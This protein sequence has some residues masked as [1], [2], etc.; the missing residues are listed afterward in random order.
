MVVSG[1]TTGHGV[2]MLSFEHDD[3]IF[4]Q[5]D[6]RKTLVE[7]LKFAILAK[8]EA[9]IKKD[10]VATWAV[11]GGGTP[12]PLF[13]AMA[14]TKFSWCNVHVALVDDRWVSPEHPRSNEGF[15]KNTLLKG[16]AACACF[17]GM[18][19]D[20]SEPRLALDEVEAAY[21]V[22]PQ[23]F[24]NV[25][26][27]MGNDGHTAS[28]FPAAEGL[29]AAMAL[30]HFALCAAVTAQQSDVTGEEIERMTL[31]L[32]AIK[33]AESCYLMITGDEKLSTLKKALEVNT[34]LPIARVVKALKRPL[35][36]FWTP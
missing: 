28:L 25:L 10:G 26:L 21:G 18:Y 6:D 9:R 19:R 27:G 7:Q 1:T 29:K 35:E 12:Q 24:A 2:N 11:S 33:E 15:I 16:Y 36:V 23:P 31:T 22:L 8:L 34:Q 32:N 3:I 5:F 30:D 13:E 4:H 20:T 14:E 17:T